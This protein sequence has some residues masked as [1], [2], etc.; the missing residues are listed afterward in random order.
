MKA[1]SG[2]FSCHKTFSSTGIVG[3]YRFF[4]FRLH[5]HEEGTKVTLAGA[6]VTT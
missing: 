2:Y 5:F 4:F 3:N 1:Q 6:F